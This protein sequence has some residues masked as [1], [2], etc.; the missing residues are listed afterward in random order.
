M[1]AGSIIIDLLLRT[2]SLE[3]DT[4]RAE[5]RLQE[6]EKTAKAWGISIGTAAVAAGA[7]FT[8]WAVKMADTGKELDRF[9]TLSNSSSE[10]FQKWAYGARS[11]GIEQEKLAD[12]LKDVQDRVGDFITTGGGPMADFFENIAPKIGLTADAFRNLSGPDALQ[13]F[14]SSLE[15]AGLSQSEMIFYMEAMASDSSLLIPL[16][17]D[18]AAGM[19]AMGD[20]AERL[21]G[22]MKDSTVQ[23][24]K[25]LDRNI[26][27]LTTMMNGLSIELANS[28]LPVL[29]QFISNALSAATETDGLH[30]EVKDLAGDSTLPAWLDTV[31]VGLA[32]MVDVAVAAG[33]ALN[34]V[35]G[36]FEVVMADADLASKRYGLGMDMTWA[37]SKVFPG[38]EENKN[39]LKDAVG[40]RDKVLEDANKR[41]DKLWNDP[42]N[43]FEQ[44]WISAR[45]TIK[46]SPNDVKLV[47]LTAP[48]AP[49]GG[50]PGKGKAGKAAKSPER[51][52]LAADLD[53]MLVRMGEAD[54]WLVKYEV[55]SEETFD[56]VGEF[57]LEAARGI[58][59]SLGDG[60]YDILSGNF[61]NIGSKFGDMIMRMAADAAAANLAKAM[62]GDF[63][64][65]GQIGGIIGGLAASMFGGSAPID[66]VSSGFDLNATSY[67]ASGGFTGHGGKYDPAGIVHK[68]EVVFSQDDV[69]RNGGV[70]RVESMRLR[71]YS[72]GGVV[73]GSSGAGMPAVAVNI[74]NTS[75]QQV[76]SGQPKVSMDSLGRLV[77]DVMLEDLRK[78]GTYA[79]QLKG[80]M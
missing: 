76:T 9:A 24:A 57:A 70:S 26:D 48:S 31:G 8:A 63:D 33:R 34:A 44:A 19:K 73:G 43:K 40:E 66:N 72:G 45:N 65:S 29:N 32:R 55:K 22:I 47:D 59:Q 58:Q 56:S 16:M 77:I 79:R 78:N 39:A 71:G 21:G 64:K 12:I 20:E 5:K 80:G 49:I 37:T 75:G 30:S 68:G 67:F 46:L 28:T 54:E 15:K 14:T 13:L 42:A 61:D 1:A 23:A 11:V 27:Q 41:W 53:E 25:E 2:G 62:F 38:V 60:L 17:K 74:T 10:T 69:R 18:N 51:N 36:S 50:K 35:K 7:A 52:I 4:K 3:T 6:M